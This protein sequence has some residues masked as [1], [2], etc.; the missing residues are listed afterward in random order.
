MQAAWALYRV[1]TVSTDP[2]AIVACWRR[3]LS[4]ER[5]R[6]PAGVLVTAVRGLGLAA[7]DANADLVAPML[8]HPV[9]P[10]RM[11]AALALGR[12]NA[13]EH[14]RDLLQ[15]LEPAESV[16]NVRL[17]ARKAL[18]ALAGNKDYGYD[19]VAWR[20]VFDR[21]GNQDR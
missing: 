18:M 16:Q 3:F 14:W 9:P 10:L 1:Q 8:K 5:E 6:M 7:A 21:G 15:L 11:A 2:S 20:K 12:M 4:T 13:Q 17:H 19:L